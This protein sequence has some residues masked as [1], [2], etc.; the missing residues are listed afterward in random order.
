MDKKEHLPISHHAEELIEVNCPTVIV[1]NLLSNS[2]HHQPGTI[3]QLY[4]YIFLKK[5]LEFIKNTRLPNKSK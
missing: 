1:I 4:L 5:L 2:Y 3:C